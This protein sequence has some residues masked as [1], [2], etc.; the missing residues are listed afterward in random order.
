MRRAIAEADVGDDVLGDDPTVNR[1]QTRVARLLGKEAAL[2][3]PSG[4]MANQTAIRAQTE[5]GDEIILHQDSHVYQYEGGAPFAL[6]GCSVRLVAGRRGQFTPDDVR[7]AIRPNDV[8]CARSRLVVIENTHNSGG[9]SVWPLEQVQAI[10]AAASAFGLAVHIDGARLF[11]ACVASGVAAAQYAAQADTVAICFSKGLGAP[12]GSIVAGSAATM[13]R[14]HRFRKMFGGAMRQVGILAAAAEY[15]LEHNV[16]RLADD[17]ENAKMLAQ[18]IAEMPGLST[19]PDETETNIVYFEVDAAFD[20]AEGFCQRMGEQG[21][22]MLPAS[23]QRVRAVTH[24][25][26]SDA[27]IEVAIAAFRRVTTAR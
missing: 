20:T 3:V 4:S 11:N 13:E 16:E 25:D 10:R 15:A 8:H 14:V 5:P 21:V 6:S 26:V 22:W 27:D 7:T 12:A 1:L 23:A 24:L 18:A 9:G 17:H 19:D 2:F